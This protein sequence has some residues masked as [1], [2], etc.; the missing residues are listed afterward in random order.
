MYS[1]C[2]LARHR[3]GRNVT[4]IPD[5]GDTIPSS[6]RVADARPRME[7]PMACDSPLAEGRPLSKPS[8][9]R[10]SALRLQR[11]QESAVVEHWPG[12]RWRRPSI[13]L[14]A[15]ALDFAKAFELG[16][17]EPELVADIL[18]TEGLYDRFVADL[19]GVS[20][21]VWIDLSSVLRQLGRR[22][23]AHAALLRA[24]NL[25]SGRHLQSMF[26]LRRSLLQSEAEATILFDPI[27]PADPFAH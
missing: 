27:F 8:R 3:R 13:E 19:G 4:L 10:L 11:H 16:Y 24:R 26:L 7:R 5:S 21:E 14:D 9:T 20:P 15:A 6:G 18:A 25:P 17:R 12:F 1:R 22:S 23:E 2:R